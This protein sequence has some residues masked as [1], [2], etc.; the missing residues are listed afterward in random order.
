MLK[1]VTGEVVQASQPT[2]S[3]NLSGEYEIQVATHLT[4]VQLQAFGWDVVRYLR[5]LDQSNEEDTE[6][7]PTATAKPELPVAL[8]FVLCQNIYN[9][10]FLFIYLYN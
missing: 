1:M 6:R 7:W 4:L 2:V 10:I 8:A 9:F 3:L 5:V